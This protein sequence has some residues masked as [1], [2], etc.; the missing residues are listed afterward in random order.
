VA[1]YFQNICFITLCTVYAKMKKIKINDCI[2]FFFPFGEL[3]IY[4]MS[5]CGFSLKVIYDQTVI[6]LKDLKTVTL[7]H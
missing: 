4:I 1:L 5:T 7:K 6:T 3:N 2:F